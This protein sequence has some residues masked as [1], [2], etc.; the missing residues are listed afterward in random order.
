M[1]YVFRAL[2]I[3]AVLGVFFNLSIAQKSLKEVPDGASDDLT[4]EG[5]RESHQGA[6][7]PQQGNR[8]E[9]DGRFGGPDPYGPEGYDKFIEKAERQLNDPQWQL[10]IDLQDPKRIVVN[11]ADGSSDEYW[12]VLFRVI[13]DNTRNI[14]ETELPGIDTSEVDPDNPPGPREITGPGITQDLEGVPVDCHL[15]FRLDV[16]RRDI[17]KD[18]Y[19][20]SYPDD[21]DD[22][23]L[24]DEVIALRRANM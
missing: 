10:K 9:R 5:T 19:D 13:N 2:A 15:D 23:V 16:F 7:N 8:S 20:D 11:H 4:K 18:P 3:V 12:Y 17:E 24:D 1:R 14:K 22:V 6:D 21:P